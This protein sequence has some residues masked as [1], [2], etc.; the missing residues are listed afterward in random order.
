MRKKEKLI[1]MPADRLFVLIGA[2]PTTNWLDESIART[3]LGFVLTGGDLPRE[4]RDQFALHCGR[5]PLAHETS[6]QG[7]FVAGDV[8]EGS[9]KRVASSVG[10]GAGLVAELH[11]YFAGV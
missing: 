3:S 9:I 10:D 6:M 5:Q 2:K 8:R 1:E 4:V 11:R 7:L